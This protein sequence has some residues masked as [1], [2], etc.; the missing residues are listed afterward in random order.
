MSIGLHTTLSTQLPKKRKLWGYLLLALLSTLCFYPSDGQTRLADSISLVELYDN[1]G[2][3]AWINVWDLNQP[4]DNWYGVVLSNGR[5]LCLDLDG[6][7][8]CQFG[9]SNGGNG[10]QGT[11][12][13]LN[14]TEAEFISLASNDLT[15]NIPNF[16]NTPK[17][18]Y[19]ILS[20]NDFSGQ[21]PNFP[22]LPGLGSLNLT[23]NN[24]TGP[25][26]DFSGL[27]KLQSMYLQY[28]SLSGSLPDFTSLPDLINYYVFN[29]ELTGSIPDFVNIPNLRIIN[30]R[31]NQ[32]NGNIPNFSNIPK[33]THA[34][35]SLNQLTGTIP[36]FSNIPFLGVFDASDNALSGSIPNFTNL[37]NLYDCNVQL[38]QLSG[39]VPNF[40]N[41]PALEKF[42]ANWNQLSGSVPDFS[43]TI[44]VTHIQI[45]NN[46]LTGTLPQ[47]NSVPYLIVLDL[48]NNI[49]NGTIPDFANLSVLEQ[50]NLN[51]N[52]LIGGIPD[53]TN[54]PQLNQLILGNNNLSGLIPD[55]SNLTSLSYADFRRNSLVS[56][57]P[58]FTNLPALTNLILNDNN[59]SEPVP[60]FSNLPALENLRIRDNQLTFEDLIDSRVYLDALCNSNGG[61][62]DYSRQDS[63][64]FSQAV[65]IPQGT[66]YTIDLMEDDTV[67]TSTYTWYK[68]NVFHSTSTTNKFIIP[69]FQQSDQ[70]LYCCS[71]TNPNAPSLTLNAYCKALFFQGNCQV[72]A[73]ITNITCG[74]PNGE[75]QLTPS[76]GTGPY[77]FNWSTGVSGPLLTN[78]PQGEYTVTVTDNA[79][80]VLVESFIVTHREKP[81]IEWEGSYGGTLEDQPFA[82]IQA[83]DGNFITAGR[84]IS[85]N[86]QIS[87]PKGGYDYWI[88]KLAP[89]GTLIWEMSYGGSGEDDAFSIE[90]TADKGFIITG[91]SISNDGDVTGL[92][93]L[94]DYWVIKID[95]NGNLQ[96]EK[97]LGGT[98]TDSA[99]DIV[100][101]PDGTFVVV[102]QS[103]SDDG[104]VSNPLGNYDFWLAQLDAAGNLLS[105]QSYGG[106]GS[107]DAKSITRTDDNGYVIAG[108]TLSIDGQITN[109]KGAV[110]SWVIRIDSLGTL[111]WQT[112]L[113]G[114][115]DEDASHITQT[116]DGGF[117]LFGSTNSIDGD[118]S[119]A[120]GGSDFWVVKL[121][122][123]GTIEWEKSYGGTSNEF[124]TSGF[125][126][127]DNEFIL[128]GYS[129]SVDGNISNPKGNSDYWVVNI[130]SSGNIIWEI[131][132]GGSSNETAHG[133]CQT[134]DGGIMIAGRSHS[135]DLDVSNNLGDFDNWIVKLN[136]DY[137]MVPF[138]YPY[139][140]GTGNN[141]GAVEVITNTGSAPYALSW[142]NTST[143]PPI[144]GS[145][146]PGDGLDTLLNLANGNYDL[147]V[148]DVLGCVGSTSFNICDLTVSLNAVF[149]TCY[150]DNGA[151]TAT[152]A[153][154]SGTYN[155]LWSTGATGT[156]ISN[157][158]PGSYTLT[159]TDGAGCNK[160]VNTVLSFQGIPV[161]EWQ[162]AIGGSGI[163]IGYALRQSSDNGIVFTGFTES[164]DGDI[165]VQKGFRDLLVGKTDQFGNLLWLKTYG[166]TEEDLGT[167]LILTDNDE[168]YVIG[169]SRSS[170]GDISSNL[171]KSDVLL[172]KLDNVGN[173][174]WEKTYGGS[175]SE[176][177]NEILEL[178]NGDLLIG[179]I[180]KSS[181]GDVNFNN[182]GQDIWM[183]RTDT[184]GNLLW[185][186]SFGG[187][188]FEFD[189]DIILE[190]N[191]FVVVGSSDTIGGDVNTNAGLSDSWVFRSDLQGNISYNNSFGDQFIDAI[192]SIQKTDS[193]YLTSGYTHTSNHNSLYEIIEWDDNWNMIFQKTYGGTDLDLALDVLSAANGDAIVTGY[194]S[195]ID[196]DVVGNHGVTD[197]WILNLDGNGDVKWKKSL[198]S[199]GEDRGIKLLYTNDGG[200]ISLG[201]A[202]AN[203]GDVS[204]FHGAVDVWMIK[205]NRPDPIVMACSVL[206]IGTGNNDGVAVISTSGGVPPY[207]IA[208][209][210]NTGV[211]DTIFNLNGQDTITNL[212][213]GTIDFTVIDLN[214]CIQNCS[215]SFCEINLDITAQYTDCY[216]ATGQLIPIINPN[217]SYQWST[218]ANTPS[219]SNLEEGSYT[220]T[221]T[222]NTGCSQTS[223]HIV[224]YNGFSRLIWEKSLGGTSEDHLTDGVQTNDGGYIFTG[225]SRSNDIDVSGNHG[226]SDIWVVKTDGL[227]NIQWQQSYGGSVNDRAESIQQTSDGGYIVA[228]RTSSTD[229]D[230]IGNDGN[231]DFWIIKLDN[232]GNLQ[233][234]KSYG[235]TDQE[236]AFQIQQTTDK[237][238]IVIGHANSTDG[239]VSQNNGS[240]DI[241]V[242]KLDQTGN[243][244]WERSYG[245]SGFDFGHSIQQT[246]DFG[247]I[248]TGRSF[249]NDGDISGN[250]GDEDYWVVKIDD[251][252][253]IQWEKS[254]GG[255]LDD[256]PHSI[257]Q[258]K[259]NGFIVAGYSNSN[260]GDVFGNHGG[261]D[262]WV[263]KLDISGTIQWQNAL[264]GT[265]NEEARD[266]VQTSDGNYL[267]SGY[268]NSLNGDVTNSFNNTRYWLVKLLSSGTLDWEMTVGGQNGLGYAYLGIPSNDG[269]YLFGGQTDATT[270]DVS[271]NIG[272]YDFWLAKVDQVDS[273]EIDAIQTAPILCAGTNAGEATV[274]ISGGYPIYSYNWS[275]GGVNQSI[276]GLSA[277]TYV[278]TTTDVN[279]C[280][281]VDSVIIGAPS[282]LSFSTTND[283]TNCNTNTGSITVNAN[284]GVLPYQYS[285]DGNNYQTG[286]VFNALGEG[287]YSVYILD[288]NN[289]LDSI[290][291]TVSSF[292]G[293]TIN[294]IS[295]TQAT[296]GSTNGEATI[297]ATGG[298]TPL[299]Y[300]ID[301]SNFQ[302]S[303]Q[304][305]NLAQGSYTA[306]VGD[307]NSCISTAS[308]T[309]TQANGPAITSVSVTQASCGSSNGEATINA[310]GGTT[311]L[312]Y[313]IDNSNFQVS[314]QFVNLGQGSYTA[315]VEDANSCVSTA[316][317]TITQSNG[318]AITSVTVTQA[319]CGSSNGEATI[320]A[321]GGTTPLEYSIDN[322]N[323]Q[324]SN[325]F[326]NLAQG[327]YTA[328]VGDANSCV[329]TASFTITQAIGP[330]IDS[331]TT[332]NTDCGLTS[333]S[334]EAF[335]SSGTTP[336][337]FSI[338]NGTTNQASAL[339]TGLG[340]GVYTV[341]VTDANSCVETATTQIISNVPPVIDSIT[342]IDA[343]CDNNSGEL[344][345]HAAAGTPPINYS[346]DNGTTF[347][348]SNT[349]TGLNP[350]QYAVVVSDAGGCTATMQSDSIRFY[351]GPSLQFFQGITDT[352]CGQTIGQILILANGGTPPLDYSIDGG[353]TYQPSD[354][355]PNLAQG[356]YTLVVRDVNG[357]VDTR[358]VIIDDNPGPVLSGTNINQPACGMSNGSITAQ[359]TANG[360]PPFLY[361]IDGGPFTA[362]NTFSSLPQGAYTIVLEDSKL[363]Y[364]TIVVTLTDIFGPTIDQVQVTNSTCGSSNG[365]LVIAVSGAT[366]PFQYS[367]DN[368]VNYQ[369]SNVF[370]NLMPAVYTI[371]VQ[372][373][374]GCIS[375]AQE[376]ILDLNGPSIDSL[377]VSDA[378]C[379]TNIGQVTIF[380]S[381]GATPVIYSIDNIN[382]Q[383]SNTFAGLMPAAY[384][385][386]IKDTSNCSIDTALVIIDLPGPTIDSVTIDPPDCGMANGV[387]QI[388]T[389]FG[390][391]P[392]EYSID[393]GTTYAGGNQFTNLS[394]GV[395][396][397]LVRDS[398]GCLATIT[399][400][401]VNLNG[402]AIVGITATPTDCDANTGSLFV[403][404]VGGTTPYNYNWS[405]TPS[406]TTELATGL[407]VGNYVV[408]ITDASGCQ[409][410]GQQ[411]VSFSYTVPADLG[412]DQVICGATTVVLDPG[413]LGGNAVWSTGETTPTINVSLAGSYSVTITDIYN[414]KS[415]DSINI[416]EI[417]FAPVALGDT[418][419][420]IGNATPLSVSGGLQYDWWPGTD[421]SCVSCPDPVA[422]P[423]D[424]T[425]YFVAVTGTGNCADTLSVTVN[426]IK[427]LDEIIT[428]P[429]VI[430]GNDDGVNDAWIIPNIDLFPYNRVTIVNRYGDVIYTANP[431][432]NNWRGEYNGKRL[433][434]GTYYYVLELD[435][436]QFIRQSGTVT[437]LR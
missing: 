376:T 387:L 4:M 343:L 325:Q 231:I 179:G 353:L 142:I 283:S 161:I 212:P 385:F 380:T 10:L 301:N 314:N 5:V 170:N 191:S 395:Y 289:C 323:F 2:G 292:L 232:I 23:A 425:T 307:V 417:P 206:D 371:A 355:F 102:G 98:S 327:S 154:G 145:V 364:D 90:E 75:I 306:Y 95:V 383:V 204:G 205:F 122:A 189:Y 91:R 93:G 433:P 18:I 405:T 111:L 332:V 302:V 337:Q 168:I 121:S 345:I 272:D 58:D 195:S 349:F 308:F 293:A 182:G 429:N 339:F 113:G 253:T 223:S 92:N 278:I 69:D 236:Q 68:D 296:C 101:N 175:E 86:G 116:Q 269:G 190:Q 260:N 427:S 336:L 382:F 183:I 153:G 361:S 144:S 398:N 172:M 259:D 369:T 228:G 288:G 53:F 341:L 64:S 435:V 124:L 186:K 418:T 258:T 245:G 109:P 270:G 158:A 279:G 374:N 354:S 38:N 402:P 430:T 47:F 240:S 178:P 112:S 310:T 298:T 208:W 123:N 73:V 177:V 252:G 193:G 137:P 218:G 63:I 372:D 406:Q 358:A 311:P 390:T 309:I 317:F 173:L 379:G 28:N 22:S 363:C 96:W 139:D 56:P 33:L 271:N 415:V 286:N 196:G 335:V 131:S 420:L 411:A 30:F 13:N 9:G 94:F 83:S 241:W 27:P 65:N 409:I 148:A 120:L 157:L 375:S 242:L 248:F 397:I 210:S 263:V 14:L 19:L 368:G 299:E 55:F 365:G 392:L 211:T 224:S 216:E 328:Y 59:L 197:N 39:P 174:I 81:V 255:A 192:R 26:P 403:Q 194:A 42:N 8:A 275:N 219:I 370:S 82:V 185:Q 132:L 303:N 359:V 214:N 347:Q 408:T 342:I 428:V 367:I 237:G 434:Q 281:A 156:V 146:F 227:A 297:N 282:A 141:D 404:T 74:S 360:V 235:G 149:T 201:Y 99:N 57:I 318:P 198:G 3:S 277:N 6:N 150:E 117:L 20:Y 378:A 104:D 106:S 44:E 356:N 202:G 200:F 163:D 108:V 207:T 437:L 276:T 118:V 199:T 250:K 326:V 72:D 46:Q 377:V 238:Y 97:T 313:S 220:A 12:P 410:T 229:G 78:V 71:V 330:T 130:D 29:N 184:A 15:G 291:T 284:G 287:I 316:T 155:Y 7:D 107:E 87:N 322:S 432:T 251:I 243:L 266:I 143:S 171:G 62:Y 159:V 391:A 300:S 338:D 138:G 147:L 421:L 1:A 80:C 16:T 265:G 315:Y 164:N 76:G 135:N 393:N 256:V 40:T 105:N 294:S 31:Q 188:G 187:P 181:D 136:T 285:I 412:P 400:T 50:L 25:I 36:D 295:V 180:T 79:G 357:C 110:D 319:S 254:L 388:N 103:I 321:T 373:A 11:L 66:Y 261:R 203:D 49:I 333:G 167:N 329:S 24:L 422:T 70:A 273:F 244:E 239:D 436:N 17:L 32:L 61:D 274:T 366:P 85:Q 209:E 304:F 89:N 225:R 43:N 119:V 222:D 114:S 416:T 60:S 213:G 88:T 34:Y 41:L 399:A 346:I 35:L 246:N 350:G 21:I 264:G 414:C 151:I 152:V 165:T 162:N 128:V 331:I 100:E 324:V 48:A 166:G 362:N 247:Y 267:I 176:G 234:Q 45:R 424:T 389:S 386:Y 423:T 125:H 384:T 67:T 320:N 233:W 340:D 413:V 249:S 334:L 54:L 215:V 221:I 169:G 268:T 312:E 134:N 426:T 381:G 348:T 84:S 419:I 51:D 52:N 431:Y 217:Y 262:L 401:L 226:L 77:T 129:N 230:V 140:N 133:G 344:T 160:V 127:S 352:Y 280:P 257:I 37:P 407:A 290:Q 351:S 394:P 305:V 126:K 396:N 115:G